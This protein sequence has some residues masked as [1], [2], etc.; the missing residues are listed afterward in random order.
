M[1]L[2]VERGLPR[3]AVLGIT[4]F[5]CVSRVSRRPSTE[6][7]HRLAHPFARRPQFRNTG[8]GP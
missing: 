6:I 7:G 2:D 5:H 3:A 4:D 1:S 8:A